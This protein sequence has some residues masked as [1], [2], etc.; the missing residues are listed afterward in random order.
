MCAGLHEKTNVQEK[1]L[2]SRMFV[3]LS[4]IYSPIVVF[5]PRP[6]SYFSGRFVLKR[7]RRFFVVLGI[8][9]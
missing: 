7:V 2:Q 1:K 8:S 5:T 4:S 6:W 3:G 9:A